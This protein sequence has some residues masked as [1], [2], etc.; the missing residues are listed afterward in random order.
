MW[1]ASEK[2]QKNTWREEDCVEV[3]SR[4]AWMGG[5][6]WGE[7]GDRQV[8]VR[9]NVRSWHV[10][11]HAQAWSYQCVLADRRSAQGG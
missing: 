6:Y 5:G 3:R 4:D 10:M 8:E 9:Q 2:E 11:G 1:N 7:V